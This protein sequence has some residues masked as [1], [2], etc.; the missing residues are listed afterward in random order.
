MCPE[1]DCSR[2]RLVDGRGGGMASKGLLVED[3]LL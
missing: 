3:G 2:R 1:F